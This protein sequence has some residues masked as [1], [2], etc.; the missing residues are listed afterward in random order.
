M[1][2]GQW[3]DIETNT[4]ILIC[5]Y[6]VCMPARMLAIQH[7]HEDIAVNEAHYFVA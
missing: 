7:I 5:H 6:S 2:V 3:C 4:Y 1:T